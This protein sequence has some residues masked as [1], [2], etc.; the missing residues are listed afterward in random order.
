MAS[1][2]T[3]MMLFALM[4]EASAQIMGF[5]PGAFNPNSTSNA[6]YYE[7]ANSN[8]KYSTVVSFPGLNLTLQL[9]DSGAIYNTTTPDPFLLTQV[10]LTG[11]DSNKPSPLG[12]ETW[13]WGLNITDIVNPTGLNPNLTSTNTVISLSWPQG[14][15]FDAPGGLWNV[16]AIA[17]QDTFTPLADAPANNSC[18]PVI[19]EGCLQSIDSYINHYLFLNHSDCSSLQ[20][21]PTPAACKSQF[22]PSQQGLYGKLPSFSYL[23]SP[24]PISYS[25]LP[26]LLH[27]HPL[28]CILHPAAN[29]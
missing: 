8:P 4:G 21:I 20:Y 15:G 9:S 2:F 16:C 23:I 25:T 13:K 22:V 17:F 12:M 18:K 1:P 26:Y 5:G 3:I 28:F 19:E 14:Q 11:N 7:A 6:G 29:K 10:G 24:Y 27:P